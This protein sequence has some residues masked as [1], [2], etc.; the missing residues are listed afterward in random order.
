MRTHASN[1]PLDI[2]LSDLAEQLDAAWARGWQP[3]DL[4]QLFDVEPIRQMVIDAIAANRRSW[5]PQAANLWGDQASALGATVW[6]TEAQ[7]F[8][9]QFQ[10]RYS[11]A[12]KQVRSGLHVLSSFLWGTSSQ[13]LFEAPPAQ[14]GWD[15]VSSP[16]SDAVLAKVRALLAKAEATEFANE[17]EAFSAKAQE[18]ITKHSIDVTLL[19]DVQDVPGG[20]RLYIDNPYAKAKFILLNGIAEANQCRA[21]WA[22][23]TKTSTLVGH[24]TDLLVVEILFTSLLLQGTSEILASG[25]KTTA[26]GSSA[27]KSW[28]NA[29]WY[30][31][32]GRIGERLAATAQDAKHERNAASTTDLLPVLAKRSAA[33]DH[34]LS[35]AFPKLGSMRTSVSNLEGVG[36]GRNF[37]NTADLR[38]DRHVAKGKQPQL[39]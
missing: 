9:P 39:R 31:F 36:A 17:S 22:Q 29:F 5:H 32:A 23:R 18:L 38:S 4:T 24:Q 27:T 6:W 12:E 14:P 8:W 20:R 7:P 15:T 11:V 25:A 28:R 34:A 35:E 10:V 26:S 19:A 16:A 3:K 33:V 1:I 13:P 21:V 2:T 30:G 37:A